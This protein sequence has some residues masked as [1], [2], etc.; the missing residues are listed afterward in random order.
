MTTNT[1]TLI[2]PRLLVVVLGPD[3]TAPEAHSVECGASELFIPKQPGESGDWSGSVADLS[4]LTMRWRTVVLHPCLSK[5]A[6]AYD[7]PAGFEHNDIRARRLRADVLMGYVLDTD[8]EPSPLVARIRR[9][10]GTLT[11]APFDRRT[12][13]RAE[14]AVHELAEQLGHGEVDAP[15]AIHTLQNRAEARTW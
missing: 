14:R 4:T 8:V 11:S 12:L 6:R 7:I 5:V 2:V 15:Y 10:I 13:N 1:D 9:L 3:S